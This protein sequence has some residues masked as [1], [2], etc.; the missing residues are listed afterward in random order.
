MQLHFPYIHTYMYIY[1]YRVHTCILH[2]QTTAYKMKKCVQ[3][4]MYMYGDV[5]VPPSLT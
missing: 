2:V 5:H 4:Y 3:L 1:I